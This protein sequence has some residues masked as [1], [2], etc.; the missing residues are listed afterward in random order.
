MH[1]KICRIHFKYNGKINQADYT[2]IDPGKFIT[3]RRHSWS[4]NES[5]N[6]YFNLDRAKERREVG[7][8]SFKIVDFEQLISPRRRFEAYSLGSETKATLTIKDNGKY[9]PSIV[10]TPHKIQSPREI[11]A[12]IIDKEHT[13]KFDLHLTSKP[14]KTVKLTINTPII[15]Q[16]LENIQ[17][18][19]GY[20]MVM[21]TI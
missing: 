12:Y 6:D 4:R 2:I 3:W 15:S 11:Q 8:N 13:A 9:V 14:Q 7:K 17:I 1:W 20:L 21:N 16:P 18:Y 10:G 19:K 5:E